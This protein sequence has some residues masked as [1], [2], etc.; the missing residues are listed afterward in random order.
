MLYAYDGPGYVSIG[1]DFA[2]SANRGADYTVFTTILVDEFGNHWLLDIFRK[3]GMAF[4]EQINKI[5]EL[6][7]RYRPNGINIETNQAQVIFYNELKDK[8]SLP[9]KSFVTG[10]RNK[11][12]ES[13]IPSMRILFENEKIKIPRGDERSR[14]ITDILIGE[15]MSFGWDKGKLAG[16]G[17]KD[18]CVMSMWLAKEGVE[19]A[20]FDAE[21][22]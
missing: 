11:N 22:V 8:T 10:A 12:M 17:S 15:L 3:K 20:V 4:Q 6:A 13:G 16:V 2:F 19:S 7:K 9:V 18:D 14:E 21:F 1:C 5:K